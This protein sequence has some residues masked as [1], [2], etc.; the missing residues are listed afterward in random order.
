MSEKIVGYILLGIGILVMCLS[1]GYVWMV[2]TNKMPPVTIIQAK[3]IELDFT[4]A[5][6]NISSG[7]QLGSSAGGMELFSGNDLS[8]TINLSITFFFMTFVMLFG[9]RIASLGVM[10]MRPI[11]VKMK[12]ANE[13]PTPQ[14]APQKTTGTSN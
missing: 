10:L 7:Q 4:Q 13:K 14:A 8:K 3:S 12:E 6:S 11:V 1:V 9:F 5:L 2:F